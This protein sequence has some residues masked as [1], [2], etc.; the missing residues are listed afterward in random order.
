MTQAL[1][2]APR[3]VAAFLPPTSPPRARPD[4]APTR[5]TAAPSGGSAPA[6]AIGRPLEGSC[7]CKPSPKPPKNGWFMVVYGGMNSINHSQMGG[8]WHCFTMF[9]PHYWQNLDSN[10]PLIESP[11]ESLSFHDSSCLMRPVPVYRALLWGTQMTCT[12][13]FKGVPA[14]WME[15][16][17][18]PPV[19]SCSIT[20]AIY[21]D[22]PAPTRMDHFGRTILHPLPSHPRRLT[23]RHK[24]L[25]PRGDDGLSPE[26]ISTEPRTE[27]EHCSMRTTP[28]LRLFPLQ[29]Y[30]MIIQGFANV[31]IWVLLM[32]PKHS[33]PLARTLQLDYP[34][35]LCLT[36][37]TL[38]KSMVVS[39]SEWSTDGGCSM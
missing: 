33:V 10:K 3:Q 23:L 7:T 4:A 24:C 18:T 28:M 15:R 27:D 8:L 1:N 17:S 16:L 12:C 31:V 39:P 34:L 5:R 22:L 38:W 11:W 21:I 37:K 6:Q 9:D 32:L 29:W 13:S 2:I 25:V 14:C 26:G 20:W 35:L 30:S 19:P 36:K